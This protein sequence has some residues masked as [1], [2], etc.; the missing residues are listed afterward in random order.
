MQKFKFFLAAIFLTSLLGCR[1][2]SDAQKELG[3]DSYYFIGLKMLQE[4]RTN[5]AKIN[6]NKCIKKGSYYCAKKS[7]EELTKIG[8]VQEKNQAV[9]FLSENYKDSESL[10]ICAR[11]LS[12][13]DETHK[14]LDATSH[15]DYSSEYNETIKL[16]M[17]ALKKINAA[18]YSQSLYRWFTTRRISDFHYKFYRDYIEPI[19]FESEDAEYTPQD[20][21][22]NYRI[23]IFKRD[24][25]YCYE[26]AYRLL[27][28]FSEN[29]LP[30]CGQLASDIGKAYLY[31][32]SHYAKNAVSFKS[33]ANQFKDSEMEFYF[34]FY[35]G[36]FYD[37]ANTYYTSAKNC[38]LEAL[39]TAE[40]P[41]QKDNAIWYLLDSSLNFSLDSIVDSISK[42]SKEWSDSSYFD[43]FFDKLISSLLASGKWNT[44]FDIYTQLDGYASD[45]ITA[46][47][48]YIYA[49]LLQTGYATYGDNS[50]KDEIIKNSFEKACKYSVPSYYKIMSAYYLKKSPSE[51]SDLLCRS[52]NSYSYDFIPDESIE[53][54]LKGYAYFGFPERIYETYIDLYKKG[55]SVDTSLFLANFLN[56]CAE[57]NH[58]QYYP[59]ALRIASRAAYYGERNFSVEELK[60]LYPKNYS[61]YVDT[62]SEKYA[63]NDSV[64][65][66]LIRSESFFDSSIISSAGA[67]GLTQLME[68]TANDVARRLK[69]S[70]YQ[71][72]DPETNI[73]FGTYYLNNL[74]QRTEK[75]YLQAFFAYNAGL[76][77]VRRWLQSSIIGFGS[78]KN[79][80]GDIFLETVPFAETREYGRK[81]VSATVMYEW[82]YNQNPD[83]A[84]TKIIEELIY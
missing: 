71:L 46:K 53:H 68:P 35:A 48:A 40:N 37:K 65:F 49:R 14:L 1:L 24:Y 5:E 50:K 21:A 38:F 7:A 66:A 83:E 54:L 58:P 28:Y 16:R 41:D 39:K 56:K 34:W 4:G 29:K 45:E 8:S 43:D 79:M 11:Q 36:R 15:I 30:L 22:I 42:Y 51:I 25:T 81:L 70:D 80:P 47:F 2:S 26:N 9:I 82:L 17:Q 23:K 10:L 69:I 32:D 6:F 33:F 76:K 31:G 61:D 62:Y 27:D 20:F 84:F 72:T 73:E 3:N 63:I 12:M 19:D 74:Y 13:T 60:F 64:I 52:Q 57:N 44:F 77:N 75:T 67:I 59:Q 55:I 18:S 78:K